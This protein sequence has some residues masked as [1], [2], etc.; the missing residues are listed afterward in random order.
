MGRFGP[1]S[2]ANQ[3]TSLEGI[4]VQKGLQTWIVPVTG[5]YQ[6]ELCGASGVDNSFY[7]TKGGRGARV[8]GS[9]HLE[10]GTQRTVLVGQKATGGGGGGGTFVVFAA[11]GSR[12]ALAGAGGT[13]DV[14]DGDP[15]QGIN[16]GIVNGGGKAKGGNACVSKS[17]FDTVT[18]VGGGGGLIS[19][20]RCFVKSFTAGGRE[21]FNKDS[22]CAGGFGGG[23]NRVGGSGFSGGG[24]QVSKNIKN[25]HT[26][27]EGS[28][29]PN[30]K[31]A[32]T[33]GSCLAR[34]GFAIF[35]LVLLG[36]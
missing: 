24:V 14:A 30:G 22:L 31:W 20:G 5:Q 18:G 23:G 29:V 33:S 11:D 28:F 17:R 6:A 34:D 35:E 7:N 2:D 25:I 19:D 8:K 26:G 12:L 9:I 36:H 1:T 15:G 16:F 27:G 3:G 4:S 32:A 13:A 10:K 21:G